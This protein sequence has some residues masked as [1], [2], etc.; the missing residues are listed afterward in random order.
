MKMD[1]DNLDILEI[2]RKHN[3]NITL[4]HQEF[5]VVLNGYCDNLP[6]TTRMH[7][8]IIGYVVYYAILLFAGTHLNLL[9]MVTI[10]SRKRLHTVPNAFMVSLSVADFLMAAVT[11]PLRITERLDKN[12]NNIVTLMLYPCIGVASIYSLSCVTLDRYMHITC[13]LNYERHMNKRRAICIVGGLWLFSIIQASVFFFVQDDRNGEAIYNHVRLVYGFVIP[14]VFIIV[15]YTKLFTV[16]RSHVRV[17]ARL[18]SVTLAEPQ[19]PQK[20]DYKMMKVIA[21]I[22]GTF[23]LCWFPFLIAVS[24]ELQAEK[25]LNDEFYLFMG[26][27]ECFACSTCV[28]N[29]VIYGLLRRDLRISM[30]Y[31]AVCKRQTVQESETL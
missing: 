12:S 29:P 13:S 27:A 30:R 31:V 24:Y 16:A 28:L 2:C 10:F 22:V 15:A 23:V 25:K 1:D 18:N 4:S 8:P 5:E 21:L 11:M 20:K 6:S 9:V 14:A 26:V 7:P 19:R 3:A 17:I